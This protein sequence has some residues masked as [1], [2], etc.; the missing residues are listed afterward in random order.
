MALEKMEQ[1]SNEKVKLANQSYE[2]IDAHVVQ[3]DKLYAKI[4]HNSEL[5]QL[6]SKLGTSTLEIKKLKASEKSDS[7][8]SRQKTEA[9][10]ETGNYFKIELNVCNSTRACKCTLLNTPHT[11]T[12]T[13]NRLF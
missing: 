2:T 11:Y 8:K 6:Y 9:V 12:Y 5:N 1:L 13:I 7:K 10:V 3:L 4:T